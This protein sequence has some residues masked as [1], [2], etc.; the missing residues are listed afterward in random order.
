L[1]D[2]KAASQ[3]ELPCRCLAAQNAVYVGSSL[4]FDTHPMVWGIVNNFKHFLYA[5]LCCINDI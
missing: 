5:Y 1:T 4:A 2:A 3:S